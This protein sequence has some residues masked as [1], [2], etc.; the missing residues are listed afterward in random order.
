[1]SSLF[2][3]RLLGN[4]NAESS[5]SEFYC[6]N[7]NLPIK[8]PALYQGARM[9][10]NV[11][12]S[13]GIKNSNALEPDPAKPLLEKFPRDYHYEVSK[14]VRQMP[15]DKRDI[16]CQI[17]LPYF[18]EKCWRYPQE[19][20]SR[21]KEVT[22]LATNCK[23][24][25]DELFAAFQPLMTF[26]SDEVTLLKTLA[27]DPEEDLYHTWLKTP[28][29]ET[30][31]FL[32]KVNYF[33]ARLKVLREIF[34][35]PEEAR[36][37]IFEAAS[38]F[39]E[40]CECIPDPADLVKTIAE[41]PETERNALCAAALP[42]LKKSYDPEIA[43]K[44]RMITEIPEESRD[45]ICKAVLLFHESLESYCCERVKFLTC[46]KEIPPSQLDT[47]LKTALPLIKGLAFASDRL[48]ILEAVIKIPEEDRT[49]VGMIAMHFNETATWGDK[50]LRILKIAKEIMELTTT[51]VDVLLKSAEP[52][53]AGLTEH[54]LER[55]AEPETRA[56]MV[57]AIAEIPERIRDAVLKAAL[58]WLEGLTSSGERR[59]LLETVSEIPMKKF[60]A[61]FK[62]IEPL[63]K[64]PE[65][66]ES[67]VHILHEVANMRERDREEV[68][69]AAVPWLEGCSNSNWLQAI[70]QIIPGKRAEICQLARPLLTGLQES[71][72]IASV[73]QTITRIPEKQRA[74]VCE[75]VEPLIESSLSY[76]DRENLLKTVEKIP[77]GKRK[78]VCMIAKPYLKGDRLGM[79]T[80]IAEI[81]ALEDY[82]SLLKS[83][84][85]LLNGEKYCKAQILRVLAKIPKAERDIVVRVALPWLKRVDSW[86]WPELLTTFGKL[87]KDDF[88]ALIKKAEPWIKDLTKYSERFLEALSE[89]PKERRDA[90]LKASEPLLRESQCGH[91]RTQIL[92]KMGS[93]PENQLGSIFI[94]AKNL[95]TGL[96]NGLER[97]TVLHKVAAIPEEVRGTICKR[98]EPLIK[99]FEYGYRVVE[100]LGCLEKISNDH[101]ELALKLFGKYE[102]KTR[103][104]MLMQIAPDQWEDILTAAAPLLNKFYSEVEILGYAAKIKPGQREALC[105]IAAP[106][107]N[108]LNDICLFMRPN[109]LSALEEIDRDMWEPVCKAAEPFLKGVAHESDRAHVLKTIAN[110]PEV[111]RESV[112]KVVAPRL[113][114]L[115]GSNVAKAL[116]VVAGISLEKRETFVKTAWP[117][118]DKLGTSDLKSLLKTMA[119]LPE[120]EH[121]LLCDL[122]LKLDR[123]LS[124]FLEIIE[125]DKTNILKALHANLTRLSSDIIKLVNLIPAEARTIDVITRVLEVSSEALKLLPKDKTQLDINYILTPPCPVSL[126]WLST[127]VMLKQEKIP[128]GIALEGTW[129]EE[130]CIAYSKLEEKQQKT[131]ETLFQRVVERGVVPVVD[132][133][134]ALCKYAEELPVSHCDHFLKNYLEEDIRL[135]QSIPLTKEAMKHIFH[136][137]PKNGEQLMHFRMALQTHDSYEEVIEAFKDPD[138]D[139]IIEL[140]QFE[141]CS[142]EEKKN[143]LL[144]SV[145]LRKREALFLA[146]HIIKRWETEDLELVSLSLRL[147]IKVEV[148]PSKSTPLLLLDILENFNHREVKILA[149]KALGN[150]PQ[151][152]TIIYKLLHLIHTANDHDIKSALIDALCLSMLEKMSD[153]VY[154][155]LSRIETNDQALQKSMARALSTLK[156][157]KALKK[158]AEIIT[159]SAWGDTQANHFVIAGAYPTYQFRPHFYDNRF[160]M[161]K[162]I[163]ERLVELN[164]EKYEAKALLGIENSDSLGVKKIKEMILNMPDSAR[165]IPF[166]LALPKG[167]SVFRA[168][169]ALKGV[170]LA[171]DAFHDLLLKG[172][173]SSDLSLYDYDRNHIFGPCEH[174]MWAKVS[175]IFTGTNLR[176][177]RECPELDKYFV[178][179][180]IPSEEINEMNLWQNIRWECE[181]KILNAASYSCIRQHQISKIFASTDHEKDLPSTSWKATKSLTSNHKIKKIMQ[182]ELA[183]SRSTEQLLLRDRIHWFDPEESYEAQ[184]NKFLE[185]EGLQEATTDEIVQENMVRQWIRE[186]LFEKESDPA[187]KACLEASVTD[188]EL[189]KNRGDFKAPSRYW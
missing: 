68:V 166:Q 46:L 45:P 135:N 139:P 184:L 167:K 78:M 158:A 73:F 109:L 177:D 85:P 17:A 126:K 183:K 174:G 178:T 52:W 118:F 72:K 75:A 19:N 147:C 14:I 22:E 16:I 41:M 161:K 95:I 56:G 169:L 77:E 11:N 134:V 170:S 172:A 37:A 152:E 150:N 34:K 128:L 129:L 144:Q 163:G 55:L 28:K 10:N 117:L 71:Y 125:E 61:I 83:A 99:G 96:K 188:I 24:P 122:A 155:V 108:G 138:L 104:F 39:F 116:E 80:A 59:F 121:A 48:K 106:L 149:A 67:R 157:E 69:T 176:Y 4:P 38:P 9:F 25:L 12:S 145:I 7:P 156:S 82:E 175:Q 35:I 33:S 97:A 162:I 65:A 86:Y 164:R 42:L 23:E 40:N 70:A 18:H 13:Y 30:E 151:D 153:V 32:K 148:A 114:E 88:D 181:Q 27:E 81:I 31:C 137:K 115:K 87:L 76:D 186:K 110:I 89:I 112:I 136:A 133:S 154:E 107:Y 119:K 47:I 5:D 165:Y 105:K 2:Q 49:K 189:A 173:G 140:S 142:V 15:S 54:L 92:Q 62:L 44:L 53:L 98:A 179:M 51:P 21:L 182:R 91:E 60:G 185:T 84:E 131:L 160:Q 94:T 3:R 130:I 123:G 36:T 168:I 29:D 124:D 113:K 57:K 143:Y 43:I 187:L 127:L 102:A 79:L 180:A 101:Y 159:G 50:R 100:V 63:L 132:D 120:E 141:S 146:G 20:I 8:S 111:E 64:E 1:M 103:R 90:V 93:I 74:E 6:K 58:P 26:K 171:E 66:Y